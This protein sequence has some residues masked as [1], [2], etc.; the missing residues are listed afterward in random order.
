MSIIEQAFRNLL[1][2]CNVYLGFAFR[3]PL[4]VLFL[5]TTWDSLKVLGI[6]TSGFWWLK[7]CSRNFKGC[8]MDSG[9]FPIERKPDYIT[10]HI[11]HHSNQDVS[12]VKRWLINYSS[13]FGFNDY[14][15]TVL[16]EKVEVNGFILGC[17]LNCWLC[18]RYLVM[19]KLST[20]L[21]NMEK[22]S[23]ITTN[24]FIHFNFWLQVH[25]SFQAF[26]A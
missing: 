23:P 25:K 13:G 10:F 4:D 17:Q 9:C 7:A 6:P 11:S 19:Q 16:K 12:R 22:H 20:S 14:R 21:I 1:F 8:L 2:L 26:S 18:K 5:I 3:Q 24:R 15:V